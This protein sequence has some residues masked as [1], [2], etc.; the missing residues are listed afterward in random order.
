[1]PYSSAQEGSFGTKAPRKWGDS[2]TV[3]RN[4][5]R[6]DGRGCAAEAVLDARAS[7]E[8]A[9]PELRGVVRRR[10]ATEGWTSG[11]SKFWGETLDFCPLHNEERQTG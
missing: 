3:D 2:M 10:F 6:C 1:M 9:G 11:V 7:D 4:I 5:L 8:R